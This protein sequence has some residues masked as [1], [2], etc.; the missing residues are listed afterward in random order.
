MQ[1]VEYHEK[2]LPSL[3]R[4]INEQVAP[5]PPGLQFNEEQIAWTIGQGGALW[6]FHYPPEREPRL[7]E[8]LCVLEHREVVAAAQ[9]M[10]P[11][12]ED[13]PLTLLWIVAQPDRPIPLRTLLHLIDRQADARGCG[14]IS[15]SRFSFGVG[16]SGIPADWKHVVDT[17]L[18]M[19]YKKEQTWLLMSGD[20]SAPVTVAKVEG[21]RYHWNMNK[22]VLEWEF[23]AYDG[24]TLA[25]E[26]DV[27][28]IPLHVEDCRGISEWA[29]VELVEVPKAYRRRGIGTW[30]L[31]EQ[32][33]FHARRGVNH[34]MLW[35][36]QR[37]RAGRKLNEKL[38]FAAVDK[39]V[40]L[41][42][43]RIIQ[44]RLF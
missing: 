4:L 17:M 25:G 44:P 19:G 16:W 15:C 18:D 3:A 10:L 34:F 42:K 13:S 28:G 20:T 12:N 8:T 35:T 5:V 41:E 36:G 43:P 32:M 22:P 23:N 9:W 11:K 37:N 27:W 26:C 24:D 29:M 7:V 21:L 39:V 2:Y 1:I 30:L 31:A 14:A 38:G 6:G 33:R 40:M